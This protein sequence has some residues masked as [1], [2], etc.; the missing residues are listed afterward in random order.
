MGNSGCASD[1]LTVG[2]GCVELRENCPGVFRDR[3]PALVLKKPPQEQVN[4]EKLVPNSDGSEHLGLE[5]D[6]RE[7]SQ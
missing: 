3:F 4:E 5:R 1:G 7:T 6:K 2:Q